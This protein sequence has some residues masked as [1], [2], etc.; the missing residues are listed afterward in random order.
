MHGVQ[1]AERDLIN[2]NLTI[3]ISIRRRAC[4]HW[5]LTQR[6]STLQRNLIHKDV[7]I[8]VAVPDT[9]ADSIHARLAVATRALIW[10]GATLYWYAYVISAVRVSVAVGGSVA[11]YHADTVATQQAVSTNAVCPA[12]DYR[13]IGRRCA[14]WDLNPVYVAQICPLSGHR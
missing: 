14:G 1:T 8:Q 3:Q 10:A 11:G 6:D 2:K 9:F 5:Q 4:T 13:D 7:S 12:R